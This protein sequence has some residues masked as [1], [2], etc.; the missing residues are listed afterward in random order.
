MKEKRKE[1]GPPPEEEEVGS[2]K[3]KLSTFITFS[4][5]SRATFTTVVCSAEKFVAQGV[6]ATSFYSKVAVVVYA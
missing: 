6:L 5:T 4:S 1:M 3:L 2:P